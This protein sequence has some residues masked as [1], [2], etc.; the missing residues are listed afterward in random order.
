MRARRRD[1][2]DPAGVGMASSATQVSEHD[3]GLVPQF[4]VVILTAV[5]RHDRIYPDLP[6]HERTRRNQSGATGGL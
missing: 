3:R 5:G 1:N 6:G 4:Q 2:P